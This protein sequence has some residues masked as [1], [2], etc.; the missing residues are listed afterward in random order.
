MGGGGGRYGDYM[1]EG[2][3]SAEDEGVMESKLGDGSPPPG[4]TGQ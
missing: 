2:T 4:H 1:A 3:A